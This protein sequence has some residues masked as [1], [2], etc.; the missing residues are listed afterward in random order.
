MRYKI[1]GLQQLRAFRVKLT[2]EIIR[3]EG[4]HRVVVLV[5][6]VPLPGR[7]GYIRSEIRQSL[8]FNFDTKSQKAPLVISCMAENEGKQFED[9]IR[10]SYYKV[11]NCNKNAKSEYNREHE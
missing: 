11:Q 7:L 10:L 4:L 6:L 1:V 2:N 3:R 5:T 9:S 8:I